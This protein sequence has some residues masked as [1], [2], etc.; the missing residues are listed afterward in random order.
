MEG[1]GIEKEEIWFDLRNINPKVHALIV[2][3]TCFNSGFG[4]SQVRQITS[5]TMRFTFAEEKAKKVKQDPLSRTVKDR[6][7]VQ[8]SAQNFSPSDP[9]NV[10][11]L[12]K[13]YRYKNEITG[14]IGASSTATASAAPDEGG[15]WTIASIM[16]PAKLNSKLEIQ[17]NMRRCLAD[18]FP[19]LREVKQ[20][21]IDDVTALCALLSS[22]S[23]P[24]L[25]PFFEA[26]V[27]GG[28]KLEK[29]TDVLLRQLMRNDELKGGLADPEE[30][31]NAV[32]L[33]H[34]LFEQIDING[35]QE[36][37][38]E[39]FTSFC[40]E[41][42][43]ISTHQSSELEL[44][45]Y[46]VQY[47]PDS[48]FVER[49]LARA[50]PVRCMVEIPDL[51][52][53]LLVE[54]NSPQFNV[55]SLDMV[56]QH[57]HRF[58]EE[59]HPGMY[60]IDVVYLYRL[61]MLA[62]SGSDHVI[63][64]LAEQL[65]T[66]GHHK[67]YTVHERCLNESLQVKLAW[68][69]ANY[70]LMSV[71]PANNMHVWSM[72]PE[73]FEENAPPHRVH[74]TH[75]PHKDVITDVLYIKDRGLIASS[76]LD[77]KIVLWGLDNMRERG[78]LLGHALGIRKMAYA[79]GTLI[80]V[81][82][83]Y[84]AI[85][86]DITSKAQSLLLRGHR[87]SIASVRILAVHREHTL[88]AI[89]V[90][91]SSAFRVWELLSGESGGG[92]GRCIQEFHLPYND[93]NG[94]IRCIGLP[95]SMS[96]SIREFSDLLIGSSR[97][98]RMLP[99][100]LMKDFIDPVSSTYNGV[101]SHFV[102]AIGDSIH[103]WD[104]RDGEHL[105][106]F[107]DISR[108]AQDISSMCIDQPRQRRIYV[109][110]EDGKVII[111][112]Y[113]TGD[114][115][116]KF[117]VFDGE[118]LKS[119][120]S[121]CFCENT[122]CL[123][124]TS[125]NGSICILHDTRTGLSRLR[126][127]TDAH[128][129]SIAC[130][131]YSYNMSLVVTAGSADSTVNVWD[132]QSL[133]RRFDASV[134]STGVTKLSIHPTRPLLICGDGP[135][136]VLL[137]HIDIV[138]NRLTGLAAFTSGSSLSVGP[139]GSRNMPGEHFT[140][141]EVLWDF[142]SR[143]DYE[144][145]S[146]PTLDGATGETASTTSVTRNH[147]LV[148]GTDNGDILVWN[149][150]NI[151]ARFPEKVSPVPRELCPSSMD[152][153]RPHLRFERS[154]GRHLAA[155]PSVF[156]PLLQPQ[157]NVPEKLRWSA[158]KLHQGAGIIAAYFFPFGTKGSWF[159]YT[160]GHDGFQRIW[161]VETSE[162]KG[163]IRLPN[164]EDSLYKNLE[165]TEWDLRAQHVDIAAE[166]R[167][168]ADV[169]L[170]LTEK[171]KA[172]ASGLSRLVA[173]EA[174]SGLVLGHREEVTEED[175]LFYST[176]AMRRKEDKG[177]KDRSGPTKAGDLIIK[178][179]SDLNKHILLQAKTNSSGGKFTSEL[180]A[181]THVTQSHLL[182]PDS[183]M[184]KGMPTQ[185]RP[186]EAFCDLS[187][188]GGMQQGLYGFEAY[189]QLKKV[190]SS[191]ERKEAYNRGFPNVRPVKS[192]FEYRL[193]KLQRMRGQKRG[194]VAPLSLPSTMTRNFERVQTTHNFDD[195]NVS[196][197]SKGAELGDL[198]V[199]MR[200][201]TVLLSPGKQSSISSPRSERK[202]TMDLIK[203]RMAKTL[204]EEENLK[205]E[206]QT[207]LDARAQTATGRR[208][209]AKQPSEQTRPY[210]VPGEGG[211]KE[212]SSPKRSTHTEASII[213]LHSLR[214]GAFGPHYSLAEV[215]KFRQ[216]FN[217]VDVDMSGNMDMTEWQ[218][219]LQ[220]MNQAMSP[221]DAQLLFMH[222]DKDRSGNTQVGAVPCRAAPRCRYDR[223]HCSSSHLNYYYRD[224]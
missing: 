146:K 121:I 140:A 217:S 139:N 95:F 62:I 158:H 213:D 148:G 20:Y 79:N 150:A 180:R 124:C 80:S 96:R 87:C 51:E 14:S 21:L 105:D 201:E 86:W 219:F 128:R 216:N 181:Q 11:V 133:Q 172:N 72:E 223:F 58:D 78:V 218:T 39:E 214:R 73:T 28:L 31:A 112:N 221:T 212:G 41:V 159:L 173:D 37:D 115:L 6:A 122:K 23:M 196:G 183:E 195:L 188:R 40:I 190:S 116:S 155:A 179:K 138:H 94:P 16:K 36:V 135:D 103:L 222:I 60:I 185:Y 209:R 75:R 102:C 29:F 186:R 47:K 46:T 104:M 131:A 164:V 30:C 208:A 136:Q 32:A 141:M 34:E 160:S 162:L 157:T 15:S 207:E 38:W 147:A 45:E 24:R 156:P 26:D 42:G 153:F 3:V 83:E 77:K 117:Q 2:W 9:N 18:I 66:S 151:Y 199:T 137:C 108:R 194:K 130:C 19:W 90:D 178:C 85:V 204:E 142:E 17:K 65:S 92:V 149:Y 57:H 93:P 7:L 8:R 55:Y 100:K 98:T 54:Q 89:T 176:I 106:R 110:L 191:K 161:D 67:C 215:L 74:S 99:S 174:S 68:C 70:R 97:L 4:Q 168:I 56:M 5:D 126:T 154:M 166:H 224:S 113:V 119:V 132:F 120:T 109:G 171:N 101:A 145:E 63:H 59:S 25:K 1:D 69:P 197:Q 53:M 192:I 35:D 107:R 111:L 33:L 170:G 134:K 125:S 169:A 184:F 127:V 129:G 91:D 205:V 64:L 44:D 22:K 144:H 202:S 13:I 76:S 50:L 143:G 152:N 10:V 48:M 52:R 163:V 220:R 189:K 203:G 198:R 123:I 167:H 187:I 84:D 206:E 118:A 211:R 88:K 165:H 12:H 49:S 177:G 210:T 61:R 182:I 114:V 81:G 82:F 43:M 71:D 175:L 193:Q 27:S 200:G